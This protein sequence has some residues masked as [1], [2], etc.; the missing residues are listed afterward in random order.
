MSEAIKEFLYNIKTYEITPH[1]N[2]EG[3]LTEARA[4][5]NL[6]DQNIRQHSAEQFF[7]QSMGDGSVKDGDW[8][9]TLGKNAYNLIML[10]STMPNFFYLWQDMFKQIRSHPELKSQP[11]WIHAWMNVHRYEELGKLSL[12]WHNHSYCKYHGFVHLSDRPTDTVFC[13]HLAHLRERDEITQWYMDNPDSRDDHPLND[14]EN[15]RVIPNK[16]GQHYIGP[17]PLLHRV[18]PRQYDGIRVSI[19]YDII[20]DL[21]WVPLQSCSSEKGVCQ[22]YPVFERQVS[23]FNTNLVPIPCYE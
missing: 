4:C 10:S 19:G 15:V 17:G 6:W 21:N 14:T 3:I 23:M 5:Y 11:L 22:A 8:D 1:T 13:D 9:M 18:I 20:D 16:Q 7:S 2:W 12:G